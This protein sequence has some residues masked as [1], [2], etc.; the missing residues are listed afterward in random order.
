MSPL[1]TRSGIGLAGKGSKI[2]N[3]SVSGQI[4]GGKVRT[5]GKRQ[6]RTTG[7]TLFLGLLGSAAALLPIACFAVINPGQTAHWT[8]YGAASIV[9]GAVVGWVLRR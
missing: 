8:L 6:L 7:A 1:A 9:G 3:C 5:F 4:E 2:S